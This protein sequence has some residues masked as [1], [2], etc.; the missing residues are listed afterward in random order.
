MKARHSL[1]VALWLGLALLAASACGGS[2][3]DSAPATGGSGG[4]GGIGTGCFAVGTPI[5]TPSG[6]TPIEKLSVGDWVMAY[7]EV[8]HRVVPA[9]VV[10][11]FRHEG[12]RV[13]QL[14]LSTGETL[15]VTANHPV[16]LP[17]RLAYVDAGTVSS[18]SRLL[19]LGVSQQV[20]SAIA[21]GFFIDSSAP[22]ETVFNI[23][24]ATHH[25]YFA[26]G[27]LVHNKSGG[28]PACY[29]E[30]KVINWDATCDTSAPCVDPATGSGADAGNA[31]GG[32]SGAPADSGTAE[33][34]TGGS[35][36][37]I[38]GSA[39]ASGAAGSSSAGA[40]GVDAGGASGITGVGSLRRAFCPGAQA[41]G[42]SLIAFDVKTSDPQ[43]LISIASGDAACSGDEL[44][45][46]SLPAGADTW[47]S[48]CTWFDN[49]ELENS[50]VVVS[51]NPL[52]QF[53]DLRFVDNCG[54]EA[55]KKVWDACSQGY[56]DKVS[57]NSCP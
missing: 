18:A 1:S 10:R 3:T 54:C 15:R 38:D 55:D 26:E 12:H 40:G 4:T 49:G 2:S 5:A 16:Y 13:G 21:E 45:Q 32:A 57:P 14:G 22:S 20:Q 53:R 50:V 25:N 31:S 43:P 56:K 35:D 30:T 6:T 23:E 7:D 44:A 28:F 36:A 17:D 42:R 27:V 11:T 37:G 39:G 52:D 24:V 46:L 19:Q 48:V 29:Y 34:S 8:T 51:M 41:N 47:Q 9:P 33:A